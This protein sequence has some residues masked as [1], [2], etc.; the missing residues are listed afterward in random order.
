MKTFF[1]HA[2]ATEDIL[3]SDEAVKQLPQKIGIVTNIQH[4]DK[5]QQLK[6]QFPHAILCGQILGCRADTAERVT[7]DVEAFLFIGGGVFH[8]LFV[9]VKTGKPVYCWNPADQ[10]LSTITQEQITAYNKNIQR[11]LKLFYNAEHVGILVS[12][13]V[14]QSDNKINKSSQPLKMQQP[15]LFS[16]R[17]DKKYYLFACDTLRIDELEN[18]PF[19][20]CWVNTACSR[21]ADEKN[22]IVNADDILAFENPQKFPTNL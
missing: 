11:Q 9:A 13:K 19:I 12:T 14:G 1:I 17:T 22:S 16:K 3:L 7:K 8:P 4:L 6:K 20:D 15:L 2:T 18:F 21:I 5:I 10:L